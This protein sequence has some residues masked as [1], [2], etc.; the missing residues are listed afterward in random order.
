[1]KK[2]DLVEKLLEMY[3]NSEKRFRDSDERLQQLRGS[4]GVVLEKPEMFLD[5]EVQSE[6]RQQMWD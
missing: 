5:K 2:E 4:L 3:Q 1:M 6:I